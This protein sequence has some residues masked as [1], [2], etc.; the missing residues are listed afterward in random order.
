M[1]KKLLIVEI[2]FGGLSLFNNKTKRK[3]FV[4]KYFYKY[5]IK[6]SILVRI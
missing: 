3:K 5:L 4:E 1:M 2:K 6:I